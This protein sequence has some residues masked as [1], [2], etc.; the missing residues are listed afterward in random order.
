[1]RLYDISRELTTAQLY[2]GTPPVELRPECF[3]GDGGF[4]VKGLSASLHAG[5]HCDAPLH[6]IE[7]GADIASLP[8]SR[9]I[10]RCLVL[11]VPSERL[12][13]EV[14]FG[15]LPPGECRLLLKGG[16][17]AHLSEEAAHD[18]AGRGVIAVGTDAL[19]VARPEEEAPVHT[20]LLRAGVAVIEMLDLSGVPE[21]HYTLF[22]PPVKIA[23]AD[24]AFCRAVLMEE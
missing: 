18:L 4:N 7:G 19:S 22:A 14:F 8:L 1:M 20:A 13:P 2:P 12:P 3:I 21:G 17:K 5:T 10:G 6:C 15:K 9:F 24:G 16:G 11:E 23:G